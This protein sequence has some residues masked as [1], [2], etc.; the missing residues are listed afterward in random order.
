MMRT[1]LHVEASVLKIVI[2]ASIHEMSQRWDRV[3]DF[4]DPHSGPQLVSFV[5]GEAFTS[6][7]YVE[8]QVQ[9]DEYTPSVLT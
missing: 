2:D 9:M 6:V 3:C 4:E 5:H 8:C 1:I 7:S